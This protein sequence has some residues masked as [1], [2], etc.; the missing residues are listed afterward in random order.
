M[1][2]WGTKGLL[3][4]AMAGVV[5]LATVVS[6]QSPKGEEG[7]EEAAEVAVAP[8]PRVERREH[9]TDQHLAALQAE[10]TPEQSIY[11]SAV[12]IVELERARGDVKRA[13]PTLER[14]ADRAS[15][16]TLRN[17]IRR[18]LVDI[19]R[20]TGDAKGA[21]GYLDRIIDESLLQQ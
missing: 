6:S 2:S 1:K 13:I 4:V 15:T 20:Q 19:A 5:G 10:R 7:G 9:W 17:A 18:L 16:Q 11:L 3:A 12:Q 14:L 21:K 8:A